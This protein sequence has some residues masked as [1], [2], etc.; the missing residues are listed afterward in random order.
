MARAANVKLKVNPPLGNLPALQWVLVSQ[1]QVDAAYQR[2][3]EGA[4]SQALIRRIAQHWNWDLCQPMVVSRR[5]DGALFVIDGQHRWC[6]AKLRGDIAQLPCVVVDYTSAAAE[7]ASFVHLNQQRRPLSRLDVF[8][9][10]VA[11]ED[12]EALAILAAL[13]RAGLQL[14]P[15]SNHTAWK[16][17]MVNNIGGIEAAWRRHGPEPTATAL[18]VLARAFAGQVLRYAGT[19]F[20]GVAAMVATGG[21]VASVIR[22]EAVL[23]AKSQ[24]RWR[25]AMMRARAENPTLKYAAASEQVLARA[26]QE[27]AAPQPVAS[28]PAAGEPVRAV[29]PAM[30]RQVVAH[31]P[32]VLAEPSAVPPD[33]Y[34]LVQRGEARW[35]EQC[36]KAVSA[37]KAAACTNRFCKAKAA[38]K[39]MAIGGRG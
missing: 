9:A 18:G 24:D 23:A 36:E 12:P 34:D 28:L 31:A 22:L 7:A 39:R 30:V 32:R 10:A 25:N 13:Q 21:D 5:P 26:M 6:A 19:I 2:S 14:A 33:R 3:V 38:P 8:K 16:P 11:G 4:D 15:H 20:P 17:G 27:P 35:C 37:A 1:L 29:S